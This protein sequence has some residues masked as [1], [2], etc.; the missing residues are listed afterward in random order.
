MTKVIASNYNAPFDWIPE[1]TDDY[2][3]FDRSDTDEFIKDIPPE[4]VRKVPNMGNVDYDKLTY[5]IENYDDLPDHFML[6]KANLFKYISPEEFDQV[7]NN[8]TFTPLLTQHHNTYNDKDGAVCLY[9]GGMYHE[10]NNSW[11]VNEVYSKHFQDYAQFASHFHL[12]NPAYLV[13]APGG[14]YIVTSDRIRRYSRDFYEELRSILDY[15][16]L[17]GEA[18][19]VERTYYTLWK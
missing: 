9:S 12:P 17:P 8:T 1:Y 18:H 19:M 4:Q 10:R 15:S 13:F 11:Y 2:F 5:I 7:K 3:I 6:T 16:Q 14:N